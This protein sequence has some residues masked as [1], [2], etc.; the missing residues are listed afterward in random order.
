LETVDT[1]VLTSKKINENAR[2]RVEL[3]SDWMY[4]TAEK[5]RYTKTCFHRENNNNK[6]TFP[7]RSESKIRTTKDYWYCPLLFKYVTNER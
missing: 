3:S 7:L 2:K 5:Q 6:I 1:I 4:F